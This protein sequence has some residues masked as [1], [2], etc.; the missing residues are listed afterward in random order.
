M[1]PARVDVEAL[2]AA[3]EQ[4]AGRLAR[5]YSAGASTDPDLLQVAMLGLFVAAERYDPEVGP[6]RPYAVATVA[7]ELKKHLRSAGW[8]ARV[9][10]RAQEASI[11]VE[12]VS[13]TLTQRL[14]RDP[15]PHEIAA[16]SGLDVELVLTGLRARAVRFNGPLQGGEAPVEG[17]DDAADIMDLRRALSALGPAERRLL[18]LRFVDEMTQREIAAEIG[19]SQ[20]HVH[21]RLTAVLAGLRSELDDGGVR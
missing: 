4:I 10:R 11:T 21:R 14:G 19:V 6:F 7:G 16:E 17:A 12:R 13:N 5:R 2:V 18:R 20:A 9:P 3:H 8:A 1:T 15:T